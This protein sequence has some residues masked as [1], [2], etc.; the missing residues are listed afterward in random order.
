MDI[1][2]ADIVATKPMGLEESQLM[3]RYILAST[4]KDSGDD[5][6]FIVKVG[7]KV[8]DVMTGSVD[9]VNECYRQNGWNFYNVNPKLAGGIREKDLILLEHDYEYSD[10]ELMLI[11]KTMRNNNNG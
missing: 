7:D 6:E 2:L 8:L 3:T 9:T 10:A 11:L 5:T 1:T 4:A